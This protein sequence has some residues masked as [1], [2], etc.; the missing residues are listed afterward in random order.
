MSII[1]DPYYDRNEVSN[2]DLGALEKYWLPQQLV[3]DLE[4]A[5]RFGSLIDA[6]IT[7]PEQVNYYKLTVAGFQYSK[8]EFDRAAE[9]KK[10]FYADP[11][12]KSL[13]SQCAMQKVSI[14]PDFNI[15][16]GGIQFQLPVRAKWDF[17]SERIDLCADLKSTKCTSQKQFEA[18]IHHFNYDRQ[19]A[20][21]MDIENKSN[22]M[23]IGI[24]KVNLKIF[25]VP[26]KKGSPLYN[27]GK[28]KYE[29]LAFK[30][31]Y[32]FGDLKQA[33]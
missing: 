18:S 13:A 21:Y 32:L 3:L 29:D 6:M 15:N 31:W 24:S 8:E 23:F 27:S 25:K 22:F 5:F 14:K 28:Q 4:A 9:M 20:F 12:C 1:K 26:V 2:S 19:A 17:F 16:C 10:V 30:W 7:E 11:F 33:A